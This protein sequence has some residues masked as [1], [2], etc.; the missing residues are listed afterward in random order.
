MTNIPDSSSSPSTS[1]E[2]DIDSL[3]EQLR[4]KGRPGER[5]RAEIFRQSDHCTAVYK[6]HPVH[7]PSWGGELK[8]SAVEKDDPAFDRYMCGRQADNQEER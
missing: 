4:R 2:I 1:E 3:L 5:A 6:P 8:A 7:K